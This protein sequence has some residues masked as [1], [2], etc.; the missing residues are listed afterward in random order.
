IA[1]L[2]FSTT[3]EPADPVKEVSQARRSAKA[4]RYSPICWS[5][6]GTT[7]PSRPRLASSARNAARRGAQVLGLE[8]SSY[9]WKGLSMP[10]S[11]PARF[12]Q[13]QRAPGPGAT[14]AD[15]TQ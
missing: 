8:V 1:A 12:F 4:G 9:V 13:Y 14:C 15:K 2:S 7:N 3:A 11:L 6:C 5:E 10:G